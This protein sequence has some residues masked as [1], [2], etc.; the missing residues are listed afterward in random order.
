M[1]TTICLMKHQ[2]ESM[3]MYKKFNIEDSMA[4]NMFRGSNMDYGLADVTWEG[5]YGE[6]Q[7]FQNQVLFN[8]KDDK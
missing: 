8:Q 7:K 5:V 2:N 1:C 4:W 3:S 6:E